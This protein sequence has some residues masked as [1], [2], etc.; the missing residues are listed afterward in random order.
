MLNCVTSVDNIK[1]LA[2][3]SHP[4][5]ARYYLTVSSHRPDL[6]YLT[7]DLLTDDR[8][9]TSM[10][11]RIRL[12][13]ILFGALLVAVTY[14]FPLWQPLL[15]Q[16]QVE[17]SF[18]GLVEELQPAY[19][20]L[21][22]NVR[23]LYL[24]MRQETPQ[25]ALA[26][27]RA[28]LADS[29]VVPPEQQTRPN[30]DTAVVIRR[31]SFVDIDPDNEAIATLVI[32][33]EL[34]SPYQIDLWDVE[35]TVTIYQFQDESKLLWLSEFVVTPGSD[36]RVAL[37]RDPF[38]LDFAAMGADFIDFQLVGDIGDQGV[39]IGADI[40]ISGYDSV[41]IYDARWQVIFGIAPI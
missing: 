9:T 40:N 11:T 8:T 14:T 36:L 4:L 26:L 29:V 24:Q 37:V 7:L 18:P 31:G 39:I 2:Q 23:R 32:D 28:Q 19:R 1:R 34:I 20:E 33:P 3:N 6:L 25:Q 35:G 5:R 15:Q 38:P 30:I 13:M 27:L 21:P 22:S 16:E 17:E 12:F 10:T 41:V